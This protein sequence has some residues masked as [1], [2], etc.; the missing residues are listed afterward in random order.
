MEIKCLEIRDSMTFIPVIC[1]RPVADNEA[2]RY[3]L[4]RDG[5]RADDTETCIIL[6]DAQCGGVSYDPYEWGGR[7]GRTIPE[8]HRWIEQN[9]HDLKDGDVVDVQFIVGETAAPKLSESQEAFT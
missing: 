7:R 8:A 1:I 2:Q 6:I 4:R 3:L 5:Y 9:W